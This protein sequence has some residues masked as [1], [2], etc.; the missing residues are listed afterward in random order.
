MI[1]PNAI[2]TPHARLYI[3][4]D[5]KQE[6]QRYLHGLVDDVDVSLPRTPGERSREGDVL[7]AHGERGLDALYHIAE[8]PRQLDRR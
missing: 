2:P 1:N 5:R 6:P 7:S 8:N 3:H 4:D